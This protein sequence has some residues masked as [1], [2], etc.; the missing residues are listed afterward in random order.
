MIRT[1]GEKPSSYSK[2]VTLVE[3]MIAVAVMSVVFLGLSSLLVNGLRLYNMN[4]V[5]ASI[6][7]DVRV[8]LDLIQKSLREAQEATVEI[9]TPTGEP[10]YSK[11]SFTDVDGKDY[12]FYQQS[13]NG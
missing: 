13:T 6:E 2:G 12:S 8:S 7:R 5:K 1:V 11:I 10:A 4:N 9:S 3:L